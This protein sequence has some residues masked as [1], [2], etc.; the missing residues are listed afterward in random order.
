MREGATDQSFWSPGAGGQA[1]RCRE[2]QE[3][4]YIQPLQRPAKGELLL[5]EV[6]SLVLLSLWARR[7]ELVRRSA[8]KSRSELD[9]EQRRVKISSAPPRRPASP[10]TVSE[11]VL[12]FCWGSWPPIDSHLPNTEQVL[13]LATSNLEACIL[14]RGREGNSGNVSSVTKLT[15]EGFKTV[16]PVST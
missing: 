4:K 6:N 15:T 5:Q 10:S 7:W 8:I 9:A 16:Q 14:G 11:D 13:L 2:L 3:A 12:C 1:G